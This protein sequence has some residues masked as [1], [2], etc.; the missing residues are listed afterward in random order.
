[1]VKMRSIKAEIRSI[2]NSSKIPLRNGP[3]TLKVESATKATIFIPVLDIT[4]GVSRALMKLEEK[5][6]KRFPGISFQVRAYVVKSA[7]KPLT[8]PLFRDPA[9]FNKT[10]SYPL[11][12]GR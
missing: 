3:S 4:L 5:L 11:L 9:V 2:I 8:N 1:M 6:N 10:G 7:Q 12:E